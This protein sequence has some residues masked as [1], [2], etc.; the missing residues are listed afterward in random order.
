MAMDGDDLP[1]QRS[2]RQHSPR[3]D[4]DD[5]I[6]MTLLP[7]MKNFRRR[8]GHYLVYVRNRARTWHIV[9]RLRRAKN[10]DGRVFV[11]EIIDNGVFVQS[12]M[13]KIAAASSV[14]DDKVGDSDEI[15]V[16]LPLLPFPQLTS[17]IE[18]ITRHGQ[19]VNAQ[20]CVLPCLPPRLLGK[21]NHTPSLVRRWRAFFHSYNLFV[22]TSM[23]NVLQTNMRG[24]AFRVGMYTPASWL[25]SPMSKDTI[26]ISAED[27]G[28]LML[29]STR[30]RIDASDLCDFFGGILYDVTYMTTTMQIK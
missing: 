24:G 3:D 11:V 4:I 23:Q 8:N 21:S 29:L 2:P 14:T 18:E 15:A 25:P 1:A 22:I 16:N 17:T 12:F 7:M 30:S 26:V 19:C 9:M 27:R 20:P 5:D 28:L 13:A 6:E 10:M